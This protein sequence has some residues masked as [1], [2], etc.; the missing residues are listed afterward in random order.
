MKMNSIFSSLTLTFTAV[1]LC[2]SPAWSGVFTDNFDRENSPIFDPDASASVG[3]G[4]VLSQ[5]G[6][7][8]TPTA[9]IQSGKIVIGRAGEGITEN[10]VLRYEG[11]ALPDSNEKSFRVDLDVTTMKLI[12]GSVS[13]GLVFNYQTGG[14]DGGSFYVA[15]LNN[16]D[17]VQLQILKVSPAGVPVTW[18]DVGSP[19]PLEPGA[20]YHLTITSSVNGM[21][22]YD[23][24]GPGI[25]AGSLTGIYRDAEPLSGGFA[26]LYVSSTSPEPK[27][28]EEAVAK[29]DNFTITINP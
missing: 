10:S 2:A 1:A 24:S 7:A 14:A 26:G 18:V 15:R 13:Y 29:F 11:L 12:T 25:E 21:F 17:G 9:A 27:A 6:E 5:T 23:L 4:Y 3:A 19:T 16:G 8:G 20:T 28:D 22:E